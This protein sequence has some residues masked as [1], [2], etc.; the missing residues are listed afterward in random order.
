MRLSEAIIQ[1]IELKPNAE[2]RRAYQEDLGN[3]LSVVG[4]RNLTDITVRDIGLY[5]DAER[6]RRIARTGKP[7]AG[8]TINKRLSAAQTF[9]RW[10]VRQGYIEASPAE[11][12]PLLQTEA[13]AY[14][15]AMPEEE[16]RAMIQALSRQIV[17][18]HQVSRQPER[19]LFIVETLHFAGLRRGE[20]ARLRVPDVDSCQ[21]TMLLNRKTDRIQDLPI[22]DSLLE[23]Y[24]R[25]F[26]VRPSTRHD[27]VLVNMGNTEHPPMTPKSVEQ[28]FRWVCIRVNGT[29]YGP[30]AAR[31]T[32]AFRAK[33][34][35]VPRDT[36]AR[37]LGHSSTKM[38]DEVYGT[39]DLEDQRAELERLAGATTSPHPSSF[40]VSSDYSSFTIAVDPSLWG[41]DL[42]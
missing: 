30:H 9:F 36:A 32:W 31:H 35:G 16:L 11:V 5:K 14:K 27:F 18:G 7:L 33:K 37:I 2:T 41:I 20:L 12:V 1:F 8:A 22:N 28:A 10:C 26:R 23:T 38:F 34:H 19:D 21:R 6:D 29:S 4:N 42:V 3:L 40:E 39:S 24:L 13:T 15:K 25:W 17:G